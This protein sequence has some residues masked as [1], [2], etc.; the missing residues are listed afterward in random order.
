MPRSIKEVKTGDVFYVCDRDRRTLATGPDRFVMLKEG[1]LL[2]LPS[3]EVENHLVDV[4]LLDVE[5]VGS[6]H[7][8]MWAWL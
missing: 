3:L 6:I 5:V 8:H 4:S 2:K 7:D 1:A